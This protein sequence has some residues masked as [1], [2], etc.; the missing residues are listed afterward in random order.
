MCC[1]P[2]IAHVGRGMCPGYPVPLRYPPCPD[3][4]QR[5]VRSALVQEFHID[6]SED[7]TGIGNYQAMVT[8]EDTNNT[9][10]DLLDC[11]NLEQLLD[12]LRRNCQ[13]HALLGFR[14]PDLPWS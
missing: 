12:V 8:R 9:C 2:V 6:I 7:L 10:L 11:A 3:R 14:K 1:A 5:P 13:Y 4:F